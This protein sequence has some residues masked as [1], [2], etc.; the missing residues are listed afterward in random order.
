MAIR[1]RRLSN[2]IGIDDAPFSRAHRGDVAI[3]GAVLTRK[4]LDGVVISAVRRDGRNATEKIAEMI[5]SSA[6]DAHVQA[7]L[8]QGIALAGFNVVDIHE[9][10]RRLSRP[11]LVIARYEPDL[12]AIRRAL[13]GRVPGGPRKLALIEKAGPMEP[14]AG[15]LVQRAGLSLAQAGRCLGDLRLHGKI[16]EPLRLAHLIA[17]AIASGHSRG[18]A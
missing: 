11:V 17:G 13:L 2:T 1:D 10:A 3:V 5:E 12:A 8:L 14:L 4:R 6:F 16:P 18:R 7:V 15:V 9:L